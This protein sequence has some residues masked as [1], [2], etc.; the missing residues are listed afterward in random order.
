MD[1]KHAKEDEEI[2][3]L[4]DYLERLGVFKLARDIEDEKFARR[5]V[6]GKAA[7]DYWSIQ[8]AIGQE[9]SEKALEWSISHQAALYDKAATYNNITITLGYAG[10][11]TIWS[12]VAD[13][14]GPT[15]NAFVG[16]TLG[17]SLLLFI[18][19]TLAGSVLLTMNFRRYA[20]IVN[21]E[22]DS[23]DDELDAHKQAED[24]VKRAALRMQRFWPF[25]FGATVIFALL[26]ALLLL[27]ELLLQV[28]GVDISQ[29][30][31]LSAGPNELI[32]TKS[33][34]GSP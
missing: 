17:V 11:F 21:Q 9:R 7:I 16:L 24:K 8:S 4:R 14:L 27:S 26:P 3:R 34:E 13:Q 10:F 6:E 12:R 33:N 18:G 19:W 22:F 23:F 1:D 31:Q 29:V 32:S 20:I 15:E 28:A 5:I 2:A 30:W 25:T